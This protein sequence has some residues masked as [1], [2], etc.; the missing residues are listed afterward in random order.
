MP[1][2]QQ[3]MF[4]MNTIP[5][6][7]DAPYDNLSHLDT[8]IYEEQNQDDNLIHPNI[9]SHTF[10]L[11]QFMAQHN[12]EDLN[13]TDTPGTV[14]NAFQASSNHTFNP[15]CAHNPL[16][17]QCKQSQYPNLNHNFALPQLMAEHNCEDLEPTD[18]QSTVPTAFQASSDHTSK[19]KCAHDPMATQCNQSQ[20]I[21]LMK[22]ICAHNPSASQVSQTNLSN[23]LASPYPP[24]LGEHVLT[25][26]ATAT[27]EQDFSVKWFKFIHPSPKPR[28]TETPVQKPVQPA[29]SP[30][31]SMH[32]QWTINLH[33]GYPLLQ[34]MQPEEY[35]P[36][37]LHTLCKHKPTMFHL[38]DDYLCP[39]K[40]LLPPG[41]NGE[42]L[43][44]ATNKKNEI[45]D[46]LYRFRT[47]NGH[48]GPPR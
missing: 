28:M 12:C 39:S 25:R 30:I 17:T 6:E 2:I 33:D 10:A 31:A 13:P 37:S 4:S 7:I 1:T 26:S 43:E 35:I 9:L 48:Q 16:A 23:Y 34:G 44:A 45:N 15:K 24:D 11:P 27:G 38:C 5:K 47:L 22:Q 42:N 19:P 36:P 32:Y 14:P 8:H 46:D 3:Q 21:T 29:Y 41:D 18:A 20:Y 40:I